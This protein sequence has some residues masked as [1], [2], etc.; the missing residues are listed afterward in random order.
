MNAINSLTTRRYLFITTAIISLLVILAYY[1]GLS[2]PFFSDDNAYIHDNPLIQDGSI[3]TIWQIF[4]SINTVEYLPIR[5]LSYFIDYHLLGDNPFGFKASN[6]FLY[7]LL[8]LSAFFAVSRLFLLFKP[9]LVINPSTALLII[10]A[11][12]AMHPAHVESV[13]WIAGRKDILSTIFAFLSLGFY[14]HAVNTT[15]EKRSHEITAL[16]TS[17]ALFIA[18]MLCKAAIFPVVA[19]MLLIFIADIRLRKRSFDISRYIL[20]LALPLTLMC[21]LVLLH[22]KVGNYTGITITE[23]EIPPEIMANIGN[24]FFPILGTL[25]Q[26]FFWPFDLRLV[27]DVYTGGWLYVVRFILA[28]LV[29]FISIFGVWRFIKSGSLI[30]FSISAFLILNI[31]YLQIA[32]FDTWSLASERFLVL[33]SFFPVMAFVLIFSKVS[34]RGLLLSVAPILLAF[35][36]LTWQRSEQWQDTDQL[37]ISNLA[38]QPGHPKSAMLKILLVD[39]KHGDYSGAMQTAEE[40]SS[41]LFHDAIKAYVTY[42]QSINQVPNLGERALFNAAEVMNYLNNSLIQAEAKINNY[43]D[44]LF[45]FYMINELKIIYLNFL[46]YDPNNANL[47]YNIAFLHLK[48]GTYWKARESF[49]EALGLPGLDKSLQDK[50][51]KYLS[52]LGD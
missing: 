22:I 4:S 41:P 18:G 42:Y 12:Y 21:A 28:L 15:G 6:L 36:L 40:T 13:S 43:A 10:T 16:I 19:L 45:Y 29:V 46:K 17:M 31:P 1:P 3:T 33:S 7:V 9:S 51:S 50:A 27:Y 38:S 44:A 11:I 48:T 47:H 52:I 23:T 25:T 30:G 34:R 26:I 39:F 5:D 49:K 37:L 20:F 8:L 32:P 14:C 2:G 35:F 24:R